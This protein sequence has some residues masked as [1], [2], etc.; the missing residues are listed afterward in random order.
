MILFIAGFM[1]VSFAGCGYSQ[2]GSFEERL[3]ITKEYQVDFIAQDVK[4]NPNVEL[5]QISDKLTSAFNEITKTKNTLDKPYLG[6][7]LFIH[8]AADEEK[9]KSEVYIVYIDWFEKRFIPHSVQFKNTETSETWVY[10]FQH[11]YDNKVNKSMK[12]VRYNQNY[13]FGYQYDIQEKDGILVPV[14]VA[15]Q[16]FELVK[17]EKLSAAFVDEDNRV[18]SNEIKVDYIDHSALTTV[19]PPENAS[20]ATPQI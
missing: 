6:N 17:S 1:G 13:Q 19:L 3:A 7:V 18:I 4:E 20:S 5:K 2:R 15:I 16:L 11:D 8:R 14:E 9:E 12:G 10:N